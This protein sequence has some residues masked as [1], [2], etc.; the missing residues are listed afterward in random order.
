MSPGDLLLLLLR[1]AHASAS[2]IWLGGGVYF[3]IGILPLLRSG[4]SFQRS[5]AIS[6][7]RHFGDWSK[8]ATLVLLGTGMVLMFDRL[9]SDVGGLTYAAI[10]GIKVASGICAFLLLGERWRQRVRTGRFRLS[11]THLVLI[12]GWTAFLLGVGLATYYGRGLA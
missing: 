2:L 4:E 12:L 8:D 7:Q 1:L 10:L 11:T 9:S 5:A 6:A 3:T